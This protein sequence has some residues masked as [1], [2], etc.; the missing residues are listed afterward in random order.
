M[1]TY[2]LLSSYKKLLADTVTPVSL[3]LSLRD[4][5][6]N[7]IMLESSDYHSHENSYS[8]I[9]FDPIASI[10]VQESKVNMRFPDGKKE[11]QKLSEQN[12]LW[13]ILQSFVDAFETEELDL[14]FSYSGLFGYHSYDV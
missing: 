6:A 11:E 12:T 2:P 8:F 9:C 1:N 4:R 13:P 7:T 5:F 3:Y 10:Q 14:K